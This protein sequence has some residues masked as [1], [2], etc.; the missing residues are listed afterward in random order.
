MEGL[1]PA[2]FDRICRRLKVKLFNEGE[3]LGLPP[4]SV[5]ATAFLG[6]LAVFLALVFLGRSVPDPLSEVLFLL[7]GIY[8]VTRALSKSGGT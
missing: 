7:G 1:S 8:G 4:G 2:G 6:T 5:R 3:P